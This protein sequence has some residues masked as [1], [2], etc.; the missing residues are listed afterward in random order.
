MKNATNLYSMAI[1]CLFVCLFLTGCKDVAATP[2]QTTYHIKVDQFGYFPKS[3]KVAVIADP[4]TGYNAGES[5]TP[6]IGPNQYQVRRWSDDSVVYTGT[7][8]AW[9][10]GAIHA[11][12][13]DKGWWFDFTSVTTLG[14]YYVFDVVNNIGS[15]PFDIDDR[16][17]SEVLK[18]AVRTFFFQRINFAKQ[19]PFTDAQ[20]ADGACFE[21]PNQDRFATSRFA[22]GDM[23]TAKDVSGGWMDAG[24]KN[25]YTTFALSAIV[26]LIE[27]YRM[28]PGVFRDDYNI[29]E[30]G[31]G[32][33]DILDEVKWELDFLKRMQDA[34]GTNGFLL[35]VGVDNHE[36]V[37]PP[38]ADKRPR[39]YLPECTSSSI[40]GCA[41]FA[42]SGIVLKGVPAL[43]AYGGDLL[44]RAQKAWERAKLTTNNFT[45]FQVECDDQ[46][47]KSGDA[48]H[49][50]D[51]QLDNAVVA[52]IYLYEATG[53]P[54]YRI[55]AENNYTKVHLYAIKWWG[56][57]GMPQQLALLRLTTLPGVSS[58]VAT[59]IRSMKG[60]MDYQN[61]INSYTAATDL[62][63]SQMDD[64][65]FNWGHNQVRA[66]AGNTNLDYIAFNIN[67]DRA[68]LYR[69]VA[70]QYLHWMHGVNPLSLVM[71]TNMYQHG[72]EKCVNEIF[73]TWFKNGTVWDNAVT[74][75]YGP[76]PGYV[77]GGPNSRYSGPVTDITNQPPQKAY[78]DW[79]TDWPEYSWEVTEPAI[80]YQASYISLLSR[81]M[82]ESNSFSFG[83]DSITPSA[84]QNLLPENISQNTLTVRWNAA[85]D[86]V[87]VTGYNVYRDSTRIASN[88]IDTFIHVSALA[89]GTGY[90]F[91]VEARDAAGNVSATS[92][93]LLAQTFSCTSLVTKVVYDDALNTGWS[94][95]SVACTR[96]YNTTGKVKTGSYALKAAYALQGM[97]T[98]ENETEAYVSSN[99]QLRFWVYNT[100]ETGLKLYTKNNSGTRS[101]NVMLNPSRNKW[102]EV[103]ISMSQLGAPAIIKSITVQN[104]ASS[105][106]IFY[107]DQI[108]LTHVSTSTRVAAQVPLPIGTGQST[109]LWGVYPNP[110]KGVFS[111]HVSATGNSMALVRIFDNAGRTVFQ[112]NMPVTKGSNVL[113]FSVPQVKGGHYFLQY[114]E[115]NVSK[116][117]KLLV[118]D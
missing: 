77:P 19:V 13:G 59:N 114:E 82:Y 4:Q 32:I 55:F 41:A 40:A 5:F 93:A 35:K 9:K 97:L 80:Y 54:E 18:Q 91:S 21:G 103:I 110:S 33:P 67:T 69:E 60:N 36:E 90:K 61:S 15:F 34:T 94:D 105:A 117:E 14:R 81:L 1:T 53:N 45:T 111:L 62:Y 115:G 99:S 72:A 2:N 42:V 65:S 12:S 52:A 74:S 26:Q 92:S 43:S 24:D 7:L 112:K 29:P 86:N 101:P 37:Y 100:G 23:T 96:V 89:C 108:Q 22:K 109:P 6:G 116:V 16:V 48:D 28:N 106:A 47:I 76:P 98:F 8:Q 73:H 95:I 118:V 85:S 17:Y 71:L 30:S 79:N 56:P 49:K 57:Y 46:N 11:Q 50:A 27:A 20:W 66:D 87:G 70:E 51:R 107:F 68:K 3:R 84:P 58:E 113:R 44:T 75:T 10:A 25:K 83:K 31:N 78:K 104:N 38:S 88:I 102:Q 39:Y 64:A 63:R